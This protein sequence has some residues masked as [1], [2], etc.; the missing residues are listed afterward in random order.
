MEEPERGVGRVVFSLFRNIRKHVR[1]QS[2]PNVI[3][4]CAQD[5]TCLQPSASRQGQPLEAD[6]GIAAPVGEPMVSGDDGTN[7]ITGGM[8]ASGFFEATSG[9]D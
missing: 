7:L 2:V 8:S 9:G 1:D 3:G 6:H 5:V 4:K